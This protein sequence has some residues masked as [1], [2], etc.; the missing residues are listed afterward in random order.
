MS[1]IIIEPTTLAVT[2][3][4]SFT[5][6]D[7]GCVIQ[8][9][10]TIDSDKQITLEQRDCDGSWNTIKINS[11]SQVLSANNTQQLIN[12]I[13]ELRLNKPITI[14][15]VGVRLIK[16]EYFGHTINWTPPPSPPS[17]SES[18]SLSSSISSSESSSE[19]FSISAS[20]S[21][22]E[23]LS[24]S[25]SI[26]SSESLSISA[27]ISSSES[28]SISPS[29]SISASES[30]SVSPSSSISASISQSVSASESSSPS[31]SA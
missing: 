26:S 21:S 2:K 22:S 12:S 20:I 17:A 31:P 18:P 7:I 16:D 5:S 10:S 1:K 6:E 24:I 27:S 29:S 15:S 13:N 23:S 28:S 11:V 8:V 3:T 30:A 9:D 19:S 25:A 14:N 4:L